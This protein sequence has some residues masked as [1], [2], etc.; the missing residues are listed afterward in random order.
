MAKSTIKNHIV[1]RAKHITPQLQKKFGIDPVQINRAINGDLSACHALGKQAEEARVISAFAPLAASAVIDTIQGTVALNQAYTDIAI[2]T[3]DGASKINEMAINTRL[4]DKK[5][6]NVTRE[7]ASGL[8]QSMKAE[9]TRH[10]QA[11]GIAA[12]RAYV[13]TTINMVDHQSNVAQLSNRIPLKQQQQNYIET[14]AEAKVMLKSA[15]PWE[16]EALPEKN[17]NTSVFSQGLSKI[18]SALGWD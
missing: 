10:R 12:M 18:K 5:F 6:D 8:K 9:V 1:R 13:D 4:A 11:M 15:K 2:A 17:Y 14:E 7:Q 16:V 3:A